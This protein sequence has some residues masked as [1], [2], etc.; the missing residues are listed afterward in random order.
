MRYLPKR[1]N[2]VVWLLDPDDNL[3]KRAII[4]KKATLQEKQELIKKGEETLGPNEMIDPESLKEALATDMFIA[5]LDE[6]LPHLV[7]PDFIIAPGIN[8]SGQA[9][10]AYGNLIEDEQDAQ[11]QANELQR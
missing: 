10:D 11:D 6:Q 7:M 2:E 1:D 5:M 3:P 4:F 9:V 8:S